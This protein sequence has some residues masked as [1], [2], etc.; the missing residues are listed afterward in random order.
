MRIPF[1]NFGIDGRGA[2]IL[3]TLMS[4]WPHKDKPDGYPLPLPLY[5]LDARGM[6]YTCRALGQLAL[7]QLARVHPD[8]FR[9]LD[10]LLP[11]PIGSERF[12][13]E[14]INVTGLPADGMR[15]RHLAVGLSDSSLR[16]VITQGDKDESADV[17]RSIPLI[18][19]G[20]LGPEKSN[21]TV[22][23]IVLRKLIEQHTDVFAKY[24][25]LSLPSH[26]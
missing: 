12:V 17:G 19:L 10:V 6:T 22:G 7:G 24:P 11:A 5:K 26:D 8:I 15:D 3:F 18:E 9:D 16:L 13:D 25:K 2:N 20:G 14:G 4:Q 23:E 1:I 21:M